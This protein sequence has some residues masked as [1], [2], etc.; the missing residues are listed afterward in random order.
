[1]KFDSLTLFNIKK[2]SSKIVKNLSKDVLLTLTNSLW[3]I[4]SGPIT[5]IFIPLY[6]TPQLQG[7]WYAF[8][9]LSALSIF[10]DLGFTTI[11]AQF[12]AHEYAHLNYNCVTK[13]VEGDVENIRKIG[14]LL[15]F[16]V[17]WSLTVSLIGFPF[18][19]MVGVY[20]F[21]GKDANVNWLLPWLLFIIASGLN[22][23][24]NV[25][26]SF[27]EG[28]NQ[29]GEI[30]KNKM[31]SSVFMSLSL[32]VLLYCNFNLYALSVMTL[33]GTMINVI[34]LLYRFKTLLF[35]IYTFSKGFIFN[36]KNDF[37]RL[38][39]KYA[40]SFTSGYFI[41]QIYTPLTFKYH[42]SIDAGKVGISMALATAMF[43][44][45][46]VWIYVATPKLNMYASRK[47]WKLMDKLLLKNIIL[48][49]TTIV[50]GILIVFV[51]LFFYS[52]TVHFLK[53]FLNIVPILILLFSWLIQLIINGL[54]TYLRAHKE[55]PL[56]WLSVAGGIFIVIS[57]FFISKY[58]SSDYLF[59]GFLSA[60]LIALPLV[61]ILFIRK[62]KEWHT[63]N[64]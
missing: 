37:F 41:F 15:R 24:A 36:W 42:G 63:N 10:A 9:S 32:W 25:I 2:N 16:V 14:S 5:L 46:N 56:V 35:Q 53:R 6:L 48:S 60:Q 52:N 40:I 39:W 64:N 57:T 33:L 51:A 8:I 47:E 20:M 44:I 21:I 38:I 55:E 4:V 3:R 31:I 29:I 34:L 43:S 58:L 62:R 23:T 17:K 26:L 1:M 18:I 61:F 22:F 13:K 27:L 28:C 59:T 30:Q 54:A 45:A 12:S 11:V 19:L 50:I 49:V 7:F